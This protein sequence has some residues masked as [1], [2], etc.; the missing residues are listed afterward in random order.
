[1]EEVAAIKRTLDKCGT[2]E[3]RR[4]VE[5]A[6]REELFSR[7]RGVQGPRGELFEDDQVSCLLPG[8]SLASLAWCQ[9]LCGLSLLSSGS[10]PHQ[11]MHPTT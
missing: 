3:R 11:F 5:Q 4:Q 10:V 9:N 2:R 6:E 7:A 1:M 8:L